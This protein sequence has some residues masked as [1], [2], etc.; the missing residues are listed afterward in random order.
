MPIYSTTPATTGTF[1]HS[2]LPERS[3]PWNFPS[4]RMLHS[5]GCF[6]TLL[7]H[8]DLCPDFCI[9]LSNY[10]SVADV[11]YLEKSRGDRRYVLQ[12]VLQERLFY[13]LDGHT[14]L[15]LSEG[16]FNFVTLPSGGGIKR[17][18]PYG[19]Q[20]KILDIHFSLEYLKQAGDSFPALLRWVRK[21]ECPS[22]LGSTPSSVTPI[23][24]R[25]LFAI[26]DRTFTG[27]LRKDYLQ[28]KVAVLLLLALEQLIPQSSRECTN[29]PLRKFELE[30]VFEARE[31]LCHN[32]ENP[33][34]LK[35]LAQKIGINEFKLKKGYKQVFGV[36]IFGD[37]NKVRMDEAKNCLL[38]TDKS[39]ADI[40]L[41]VGYGDPPNFIRAFK[42]Y[43]GLPPKQFRML[44]HTTN[45]NT[46]T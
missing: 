42:N 13:T 23:M 30:K 32:L 3:G 11:G 44:H 45:G 34:T 24:L 26:I 46:I 4:I 18:D 43:F 25:L 17:F 28:S 5:S 19:S 7:F 21:K 33:P 39:I 12:F 41:L 27:A 38:G 14:E 20:V 2:Q 37:F 10:F 16:Q 8:D 40:A 29:S 9:R 1:P 35:Q 22:A 15:T 31:F 6:S 36:T